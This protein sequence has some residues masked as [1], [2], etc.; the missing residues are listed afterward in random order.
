MTPF[1]RYSHYVAYGSTD[2]ATFIA[3][4]DRY[5]GLVV[6]ATIA[7]YQRQGTGGFVLTLSATPDSPPYVIDPRFPLFQQMLPTPK[8]S[9]ESLAELLDD[10]ALIADDG[11]QP[12]PAS[13]PDG[14]V[15]QIARKWVEFNTAYVTAE[16]KSFSKY[17]RR[18]GEPVREDQ[19]RGPEAILPPYFACLGARDPWWERSKLFYAE[20]CSAA[21][22]TGLP[23]YR[24]VCASESAVLG[25]LLADLRR[26]EQLV[27]W[28]SALDEHNA[29]PEQLIA[30]R[31]AIVNAVAQGHEP[32]GLYGGFFSVLLG[33]FGLC[34]SSHGVGFSEHRAWEELPNAG[35]PPARYYLRRAHRYV[36][37]DLAQQF[38]EASPGL[39]ACPCPHCDGRAPIEL[40]YHDLMKH[41]VWCR[42]EEIDQW[43]PMDTRT[44]ARALTD[45]FDSLTIEINQAQ[46]IAAATKR[47]ARTFIAH[48]PRWSRA[49]LA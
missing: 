27:I 5:S 35:A 15:Q 6:P 43:V 46:G 39:T 37:Q 36:M 16:T 33:Q 8:K 38:S 31:D 18:L 1:N 42:A 28:A 26:P 21:R 48:L 30:Y 40:D 24:V 12:T 32:F 11:S 17:A 7:A 47:R 34:G 4:R 23:C 45:E 49:L 3:L 14:R 19:A 22:N 29:E 20:T 2:Q 10:P 25:E 13:F 9:H 41:S 44:T